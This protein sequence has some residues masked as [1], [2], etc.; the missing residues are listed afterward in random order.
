MAYTVDYTNGTKPAL[1]V[2]NSSVNT[3]TNLGLVGRGF[4]NY[5]E[6]T[7][8][9]FLHLLENF[10]NGAAPTKPV[11]GQLWFDS[12]TNTL[13]YFDDTVANS[14]NWKP[15]ASM[16]VT[17][18]APTGIGETDGHF[19]LDSNNGTLSLYYNGSWSNVGD[20]G[21]TT[22]T[23]SRVR[24]DT[25][26]GSH[27][28]REV[29]VD[30]EIVAI[31]TVDAAWAPNISGATTEYLE[32]GI[33]TLSTQFPSLAP[34]VTM[35]NS[36]DYKFRG[37]ATSAEYADLAERYHADAVYDAGTVVKL[38]GPNEVT[39]TVD[40]LDTD[41]FGVVSENPAFEMNS[42][43]G[44]NDTHPYIALAG[45]VPA[46][47]AG[48]VKKGDRLV[49]SI[50]PGHLRAVGLDDPDWRTVVGRALESKP[51]DGV[52]IIEIVVGVK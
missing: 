25:I 16:T 10:A 18:T 12:V 40:E 42:A 36:G 43:A 52:G 23:E 47:V 22:R 26:G 17:S 48:E 8:E 1:S 39:Q 35:N 11:E 31:Y 6:I 49:T 38:G 2:A 32:D 51:D 41:V 4:T 19:W 3:T 13:K 34:G 33:T 20:A 27:E 21:A 46:K 30:G 5:G 50:T 15:M 29:I 14:G 44:T 9:N 45:R 28:T 24:L 7:A 37:R